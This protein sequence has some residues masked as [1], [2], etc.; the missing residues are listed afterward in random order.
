[1][2]DTGPSGEP[3]MFRHPAVQSAC[4]FMGETLCLIPYFYMRWR[5]MRAKRA[6]PDYVP[7]PHHE[8]V[9]RR[10]RRIM[11]FVL[12]TL[13]D[14]TGSSLMNIGLFYT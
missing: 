11:A 7:M 1:M 3:L 10:W 5:R 2:V 9:A 13:C 12:P 8:K 4:M 6:D 14:A